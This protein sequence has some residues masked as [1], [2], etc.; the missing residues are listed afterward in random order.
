MK[1]LCVFMYLDWI[2]STCFLLVVQTVPNSKD[3]NVAYWYKRLID[4]VLHVAYMLC[5]VMRP[6]YQLIKF[7]MFTSLRMNLF[8]VVLSG[9]RPQVALLILCHFLH[10]WYTSEQCYWRVSWSAHSLSWVQFI[11]CEKGGA[12]DGGLPHVDVDHPYDS[13]HST[14]VSFNMHVPDPCDQLRILFIGI[15]N[16]S[17][18]LQFLLTEAF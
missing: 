13:P 4:T 5:V 14:V 2:I 10:C 15:C 7:L 18:P 9:Q 17:T 12:V 6:S 1:E 3:P 11:L 8:S 16:L